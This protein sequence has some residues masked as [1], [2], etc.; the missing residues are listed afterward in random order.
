M[1]SA[2]PEGRGA[3][4]DI[5]RICTNGPCEA[6]AAFRNMFA[7][8]MPVRWND[9]SQSEVDGPR[10]LP[11]IYA[12]PGQREHEPAW[13]QEEHTVR[14]FT[15]MERTSCICGDLYQMSA[16]FCLRT[17]PVGRG[18]CTHGNTSP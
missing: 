12:R 1:S 9:F 16:N 3:Y 13:E 15:L 7:D 18:N 14:S 8:G 10:M 6:I 2:V 4:I 17:L 5:G 11:S